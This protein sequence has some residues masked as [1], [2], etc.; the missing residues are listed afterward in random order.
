MDT[1]DNENG[2]Q[3]PKHACDKGEYPYAIKTPK[4]DEYNQ[5]QQ[6]E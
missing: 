1:A 3:C 6:G 2:S 4:G 5:E